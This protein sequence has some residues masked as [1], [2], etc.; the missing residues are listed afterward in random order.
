M[1]PP[2]VGPGA[3]P[4]PDGRP[5]E[6]SQALGSPLLQTGAKGVRL[7]AAVAR[8]VPP[9]DRLL[10]LDATKE[11]DGIGKWRDRM[12]QGYADG[13]RVLIRYRPEG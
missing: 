2:V 4:V 7:A 1:P 12:R 9:H 8:G 11:P 10:A 5:W 13:S 6:P 3:Q